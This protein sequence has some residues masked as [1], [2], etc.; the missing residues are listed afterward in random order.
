[1][2]AVGGVQV[3]YLDFDG[4]EGVNYEGPVAIENLSVQPFQADGAGLLGRER[5]L[6]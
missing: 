4:A 2:A 5:I 1:M 6:H 3:I